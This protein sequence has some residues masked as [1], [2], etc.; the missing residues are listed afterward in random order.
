MIPEILF[1]CSIILIC[2]SYIFFPWL[3]KLISG[4]MDDN[5]II[6][7]TED[8][9]PYISIIVP[10]FNEEEVIKDKIESIYYTCYPINNFEVLIG[11]DASYDNTNLICRIFAENYENLKFIPFSSR[12][13]KPSIINNLVQDARGEI[14]VIT[15]ANVMFEFN[16]LIEL[17]KHFKNESIGLVDSNIKHSGLRKQGISIQENAY[18]SREI[19]IKSFESRAWGCMMGPSGGCYAVRKKLFVP[20]PPNFLVDDF[21][22]NMMVLSQGKKTINNLEAIVREDVSDDI[23]E[24]FRRKVRIAAGNFQ[25]LFRFINLLR[26]AFKPLVFCFISHKVLRWLGPIFIL[27][28]LISSLMLSDHGFFRIVILVETLLLLIPV[29][30]YLLKKIKIHIVFLRFITHFLSMNFA[31][32]LGLIKFAGG[33]NT[34]IWQPTRRKQSE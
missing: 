16:T 4:G 25:N 27:T 21:F 17:I 33:I 23:S 31:L 11:S 19:R 9:L 18:V 2:Y 29:L 22:I 26:S 10:A 24:E 20:V 34:N 14:L 30:D 32:F 13:G 8:E 1:W 3:I 28:A 12:I 6:Y 15:D 5:H 7:E